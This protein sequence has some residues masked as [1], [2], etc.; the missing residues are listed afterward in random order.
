MR[1]IRIT[2][3]LLAHLE[4]ELP[5]E[6]ARQVSEHLVSC[7]SCRQ[8]YDEI[9]LG[10]A[11]AR[12]LQPVE[13]PPALAETM[14][15]RLRAAGRGRAPS[16]QR[17]WLQLSPV[18]LA[19]SLGAAAA[20][21]GGLL[22]LQHQRT[23]T[24]RLQVDAGPLSGFERA[25]LSFHLRRL[26]SS[27]DYDLRTDSASEL[28]GWLAARTGLEAALATARPTEDGRRYQ[29]VGAKLMERA[30]VRYA[31]VAYRIDSR[32]VTLL[33]ARADR[34]PQ[35]PAR[36]LLGKR[37]HYRFD[38][39]HR[40]KILTWTSSGQTYSLISDLPQLGQQSCFVCHTDPA[41]RR[42][43]QSLAAAPAGN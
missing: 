11:L 7:P 27:A 15:A 12:R 9:K 4:G 41:R 39:E 28:K 14:R 21:V 30:G 8:R 1:H 37:I 38:P 42:V 40:L 22:W 25:A 18:R 32:P 33:T 19:A 31:A 35:A 17:G 16:P 43:I 34:L 3:Q 36:G 6:L 2:K 20:L 5:G 23:S 24:A 29:V 10:A 13:M 26:E